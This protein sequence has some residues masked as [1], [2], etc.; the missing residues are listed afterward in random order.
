TGLS[1]VAS[2]V[3]RGLDPGE[4][5]IKIQTH[6]YFE[7]PPQQMVFLE[8]GDSLMINLEADKNGK[9]SF[10]RQLYLDSVGIKGTQYQ[11]VKP[12]TVVNPAQSRWPWRAGVVQNQAV[13]V[14]RSDKPRLDLMAVLEPE[15][16]V[17]DSRDQIQLNRPRLAWFDLRARD[18][19]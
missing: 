11:V 10:Q 1:P 13:T 5:I 16:R 19:K 14:R 4:Y 18:A 7:S 15:L 6:E 2:W 8:G 17:R 3:P 12:E 9:A